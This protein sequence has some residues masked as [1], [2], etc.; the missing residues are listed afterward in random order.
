MLYE[1]FTRLSAR[2]PNAVSGGVGLVSGLTDSSTGGFA[3]G[4]TYNYMIGKYL[5]ADFHVGFNF[6]G[7]V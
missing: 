7:V 5:W 2:G 3:L 1:V 4:F 6:G